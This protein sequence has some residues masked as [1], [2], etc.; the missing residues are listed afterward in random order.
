MALGLGMGITTIGLS[1]R[2]KTPVITAWSTPGAAL[3]VTS[4]PGIPMAEAIGA[5][6]FSASLITLCGVTGWFEKI[7]DRIPLSIAAAMLGG[8]LFRFGVDVFR[9]MESRFILVIAMFAVYLLAKRIM[10]RYAIIAVLILGLVICEIQGLLDFSAFEFV[11][12][13]P[14]F[15][16]P[17]FTPSSL[18][19]IGIPLFVVT[20]V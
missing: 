3:L 13:Q 18:I 2:Y 11:M 12:V 5:F 17:A 6:L 14:Q 8:I 16:A 19:G 20:M 4:L 1:L 7:I 10:P 15:V 9:S